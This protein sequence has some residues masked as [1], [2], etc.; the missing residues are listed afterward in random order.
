MKQK[1][2]TIKYGLFLILP[3]LLLW[4]GMY[5]SDARGPYWL[6]GNL[7]PDYVY[8]LNAS[9]MADLQKVGHID[10]PGTTVQMIGAITIRVAHLFSA[11]KD[12]VHTDVL[13]NPEKYLKAINGVF[14]VLNGLMVLLLG[15]GAYRITGHL[16]LS[17]LLQCTPFLPGT[18]LTA[19]L[20][21]VRPEPL[22]LCAGLLLILFLVKWATQ[23]GKLAGVS[24]SYWPALWGGAIVGFGIATKITFIPLVVIPLFIFP[25]L[26]NKL[27]YLAT[28]LVSFIFFTL[29][30]MGSYAKFLDWIYNLAT[31]KGGY[32]TGA[33][34]VFS[35]PTTLKNSG[36]M[37]RE[38]G[39]FAGLLVFSLLLILVAVLVPRL[40]KMSLG[41]G[42]FK[43][44]VGVTVA[45]ILAIVMV[46]KHAAQH[47]LL[48]ALSVVGLVLVLIYLYLQDMGIAFKK[49]PGFIQIPF[50]VVLAGVMLWLNPWQEFK[51]M[52]STWAFVRQEGL[53]INEKV[54]SDY[55]GFAK[56]YYYASSSRE[57]ALKFGNDL[58]LN[59]HTEVLKT[60]YPDVYFY[61]FASGGIFSF[62]YNERVAMA[63]IQAKYGAK[64]LFQGPDSGLLKIPGLK[65]S[66]YRVPGCNREYIFMGDQT[67]VKVFTTIQE[68]ITQN[69]RGGATLVVPVEAAAMV[70]P[71]Q[72]D[73]AIMLQEMRKMSEPVFL[74]LVTC[75]ENPYFVVP[76]PS[77]YG[78]NR[79][80]PKFI[81][82]LQ[83]LRDWIEIEGTLP[84]ADTRQF[85][86][87]RKKVQGGI[88]T[89]DSKTKLIELAANTLAGQLKTLS[90]RGKFKF[91]LNKVGTGNEVT[92]SMVEQAQPP[93]ITFN[94]FGYNADKKGL[95]LDI[96]KI[97]TVYFVARVWVPENLLNADNHLFIQD[98]TTAWEREKVFFPVPGWLT[99]VVSKKIRPHSTQ[100]LWGLRFTPKTT[101]EKMV[102]K[103]MRV[104]VKY[105]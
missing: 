71:L 87:G 3:V 63:R 49:K 101:Q 61:D 96:A 45:D 29:P 28:T 20:A 1:S 59:K 44:L 99:Y 36:V 65:L 76:V 26:K 13:K 85:Y 27:F 10:H 79:L 51:Q 104:F 60:L 74:N 35:W 32:G 80:S 39:L 7:D 31:H 24:F 97:D 105:K 72:Q 66:R 43:V 18:V 57:Y 90:A 58:A 91:D 67:Q 92:V 95:N 17:L 88:G 30:I 34:E 9:N 6:S 73:Y 16:A 41:N 47:Y 50:W 86:M 78:K 15:V 77:F 37:L 52:A 33:R 70:A 75:L 22:L 81:T 25:R 21:R 84:T 56:I 55:K 19:S 4:A 8:L 103:D 38:N 98:F 46:S 68:W 42:Y 12:N 62:D 100:L 93:V 23:H 83:K 94:I 54:A 64:I 5:L 14:L 102:V 48:P 2:E 53:N 89:I 82:R 69:V 40:R 11:T